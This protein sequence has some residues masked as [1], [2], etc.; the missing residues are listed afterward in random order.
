MPTRRQILRTAAALAIGPATLGRTAAARPDAPM[1]RRL[2][3]PDE[4]LQPQLA[5]DA[6]GAV[7]LVALR[8]DPAAADL[9]YARLEPGRDA[10]GPTLRVND[11]DGSGIAVG[12]VRGPH[13]A[14]GRDGRVHVAW[15]GSAQAR[16]LN[17]FHSTPLLYARSK[18]DRSA[19][20]PERNL[21]LRT[22]ALDGGGTLAADADGHVAVAWHGQTDDDSALGEAGRRIWV[23]R[24][25]DDGATFAPETAPFADPTGACGC[26]GTRALADRRGTFYLLYRSATREVDRD[27]Y[28]LTSR[29][30]GQTARGTRLDRWKV[31]TCPMSTAAL[32]EAPGAVVAAWETRGQVYFSRI[33][34]ES[35]APSKPIAP[36]GEAPRK[37][38]AVA[39]NDRGE[40]LLAWAEGT[41]WQRGG[42]LAWQVFD[43]DG[44]PTAEP[45]RVEGGI[46]T[47]GSPAAVARPDGSFL[48]VH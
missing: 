7:H 31:T 29:D 2:P 3:V 22:S 32:A 9:V 20:E 36:P 38:P 21:M 40:I 39:V 24:S 14:I 5:I 26:C 18:A 10:F 33:D 42:S 17:A 13:L 45:G 25:A 47:W 43:R 8:G 37:H 46:P 4:G 23:A 30:H 27:L 6:D 19:F 34:P 28:L 41:G 44:R 11:R 1:V 12:T 48:I 15:N 16:P 35:L